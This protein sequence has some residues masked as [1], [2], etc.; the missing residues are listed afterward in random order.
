MTTDQQ[1]MD[2]PKM[3]M[4]AEPAPRASTIKTILFHVHDDP[5]L[6]SRLQAV[7]SLARAS[8]AHIHL[9]HVTPVE[10]Y[11]VV[12]SYGGT[13]ISGEIVQVIE[14]QAVKLKARLES[15]ITIEDVSWDYHHTT[16]EVA[17]QI[18]HDA[19]LSDLIVTG[20]EPR[21]REFGGTAMSLLGDLLHRARTP[22]LILGDD[23]ASFDPLGTAV[24]AWNGSYEAANAVRGAWGLLNLAS[25]VRIIQL[26]EEKDEQFPRT[27]LLEYLSRHGI[28][29]A[30]DSQDA[31]N[32][33]RGRTRRLRA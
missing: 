22:Q 24:I 16:A 13:Y 26:T 19:A 27:E 25:D 9:L 18:I 29:A 3:G 12:D 21:R 1:L 4:A 10:A 11:S 28:H 8:S 6:D 20:R 31:R 30:F 23:S 15:K 14:E 32:A 33:D 17:N 7:L 2:R 5:T